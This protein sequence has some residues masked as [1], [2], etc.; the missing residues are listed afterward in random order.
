MASEIPLGS[1]GAGGVLLK[2]PTAE[3][4][5]CP[6][7]VLLPAIA[8]VNDYILRVASGLVER[9]FAVLAVDYHARAGAPPDLSTPEKIM[10]AVAA[11]A[12]DHVLGDVDEALDHLA[13]DADVDAERVGVLG[14]CIGGSEAILAAAKLGSRL[15]CAVAFYGV[16]RYPEETA[17]KPLSPLEAVEQ[18]EIPMLGHWGDADHLVPVDD[19]AELGRRLSGRQAEILTYPG[20]GHAFHEDF[21]DVYRPVAATE[22]WERSLRYFDWYLRSGPSG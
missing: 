20:A 12:D 13:D 14:F 8:G 2:P 19:V 18:V 7:I 6:A 15:R 4:S 9:G 21:R 1:G 10:A 3:G 5:T 16:L 22:A 11:L 17:T